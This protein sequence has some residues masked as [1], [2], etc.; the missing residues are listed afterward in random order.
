MDR[1]L[2][3]VIAGLFLGTLITGILAISEAKLEIKILKETIEKQKIE[4]IN[5][6]WVLPKTR[7]YK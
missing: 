5:N 6:H 1:N 3:I 2:K 7:G 4:C